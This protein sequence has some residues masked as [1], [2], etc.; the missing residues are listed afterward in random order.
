[1]T[2]ERASRQLNVKITERQH[3]A[4]QRY[5]SRRRTPVAWLIKDFVDSLLDG[6]QAALRSHEPTRFATQ[7]GS[8]DWLAKEPDLYT[9]ADG[10]P[11]RGSARRRS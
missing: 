9:E 5:A 1:M 11:V 10:E 2:R 4:L 3:Q 8:F 6:D 7:G